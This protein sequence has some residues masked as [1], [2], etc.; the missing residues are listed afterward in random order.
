MRYVF[1]VVLGLSAANAVVA[2]AQD[3][4]PLAQ[5]MELN[6]SG[7]WE[8]AAELAQ[9]FLDD[10]PKKSNDERC[11]AYYH[12]AYA[13]TRLGLT[14]KA[15]AGLMTYEGK[16]QDVAPSH[17]LSLEVTRLRE[18]LAPRNVPPPVRDDKFWRTSDPATLN[19]NIS[20]LE[21]HRRLC[22]RTGAD[23]CLV[24]RRGK[25]VQEFYSARYRRPMYAMS[26][27]K[28][29]TGLLVGMLIDD[30]KIKSVDEPVCKYIPEWCAE[31]RSKVTV[32]HLLTMTSGLPRMFDDGVASTNDKNR[33]VTGLSPSKEPGTAWAYSNE[34]VQLLSPILDKAAGEPI[35]DYALKRLFRPLGMSDTRLHL[36]EKGHAWTYADM[37]TTPR[38]LAR[39]GLL[40]LNKGVWRGRRIVSAS[41]VEQSIRR[42]QEFEPGYGLLWWLY[43]RPKGYAALG[44]LN[45]NLYIF[46]EQELII[47]RMQSKPL[48]QQTPYEPEALRLFDQLIRPET[49]HSAS[50]W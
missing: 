40:M 13:Q 41:W 45:T 33:L 38:D 31:R 21:S 26:S 14:E 48:D 44:H 15:Q 50:R 37:E 10:D 5:M 36:D 27:T 23:A 32:R 39:I 28:S 16:C 3:A 35:Q 22:E 30:G 19:V 42:S 20:T 49:A 6:R 7:K 17:W 18:E 11:E 8:S 9:R 47:V 34:G 1:I 4:S 43:D 2:A 46:P 24:V 12:L 25:I 29:I